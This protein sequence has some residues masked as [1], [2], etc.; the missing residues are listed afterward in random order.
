M[1]QY[2][3]FLEPDNNMKTAFFRY[4]FS[5]D[6][7]AVGTIS[8]DEQLPAG[9][10]VRSGI[11]HVTTAVTSGG[12]AT[13]ALHVNSSED[14]LAATGKASLTLNALLDVVPVGTA[15]TAIRCTANKGLSVVIGTAALTAGAFT[16]A[17]D[18]VITG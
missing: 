7:G 2:P 1:A 17:L 15:A 8:L 12:S 9:A 14:I 5:K 16:V 4:D 3:G 11:L 10:L 6:G 18:Y 13:V